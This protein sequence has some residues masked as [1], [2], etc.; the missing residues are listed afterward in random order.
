[1]REFKFFQKE[2]GIRFPPLL[3]NEQLIYYYSDDVHNY[4]LSTRIIAWSDEWHRWN[5]QWTFTRFSGTMQE[6]FTS[7]QSIP[8]IKYIERDGTLLYM[9]DS[10]PIDCNLQGVYDIYYYKY[11]E[12]EDV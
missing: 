7:I 11:H 4:T 5:P 1:M 3:H 8:V 12:Y 6:F 2:E 10:F 9:G